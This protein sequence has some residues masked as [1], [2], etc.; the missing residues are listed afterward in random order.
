MNVKMS[1]L[2]FYHVSVTFQNVS[3][4]KINIYISQGMSLWTGW[5]CHYQMAFACNFSCLSGE[6]F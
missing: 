1:S 4:K 6:I 3:P 2:N 5:S